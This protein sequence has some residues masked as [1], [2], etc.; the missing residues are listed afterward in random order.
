[1]IQSIVFNISSLILSDQ[2]S[3]FPMQGRTNPGPIN[4]TWRKNFGLGQAKIE[5]QWLGGKV[6]LASGVL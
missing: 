2:N 4:Y 3:A 6:K 1:M 5:V